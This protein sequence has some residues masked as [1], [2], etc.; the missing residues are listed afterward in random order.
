M[1][2]FAYDIGED[3]RLELDWLFSGRVIDRRSGTIEVHLREDECDYF[4]SCMDHHG[5]EVVGVR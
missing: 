1:K 5:K 2:F 3:L 4:L